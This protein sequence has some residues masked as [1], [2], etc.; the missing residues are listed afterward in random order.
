MLVLSSFCFLSLLSLPP[1]SPSLLS[2]PPLPPLPPSLLYI[3]PLPPSLLYLIQGVERNIK[4]FQ[5]LAWPDYGVPTSGSTVLDL[6]SVVREAAAHATTTTRST[7]PSSSSGDHKIIVHCSAGVG[8]SGAFCVIH[9]C[10]DEFR[11]KGTVN[12]QGA[13][14]A[15]RH[16]RAY[17]IQTDEQYEFCY[18]TILQFMKTHRN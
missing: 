15:L 1:P 18:R 11:E 5:F 6:I 12:V 4:H 2:L 17:A 13:V 14:R 10:I 8:R 7:K 3:P 16:Q 9:N